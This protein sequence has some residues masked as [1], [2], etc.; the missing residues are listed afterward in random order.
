MAYKGVLFKVLKVT[1]INKWGG[2]GIF[3]LY[4]PMIDYL[5]WTTRYD[6]TIMQFISKYVNLVENVSLSN[7]VTN[8]LTVLFL[9]INNEKPNSN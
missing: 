2:G 4:G 3:L 1:Q 7:L 6:K 8:V 5:L 9:Q